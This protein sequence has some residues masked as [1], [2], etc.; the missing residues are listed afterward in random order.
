MDILQRNA[1]MHMQLQKKSQDQWT[2]VIRGLRKRQGDQVVLNKC[3]DHPQFKTSCD[4]MLLAPKIL[5]EQ[6]PSQQVIKIWYGPTL[7]EIGLKSSSRERRT[8]MQRREM[9]H[10]VKKRK[11]KNFRKFTKQ[12]PLR[13]LFIPPTSGRYGSTLS[14]KII[15]NILQW[16]PQE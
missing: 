9:D 4:M 3:Q 13:L 1:R 15:L 2:Q 14:W 16:H 8:K 7:L 12:I 5:K 10:Q 11:K 6:D